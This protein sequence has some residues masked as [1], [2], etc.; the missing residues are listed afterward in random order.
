MPAR[1]ASVAG[2]K[3]TSAWAA[4]RT[5][6]HAGSPPESPR[7]PRLAAPAGISTRTC[8]WHR[9]VTTCRQRLSTTPDDGGAD[10]EEGE[11]SRWRSRAAAAASTA[12]AAC[13]SV[14]ASSAAASCS[15]ASLRASSTL[16]SSKPPTETTAMLPA[17]AE[18]D[19]RARAEASSSSMAAPRK[20]GAGAGAG[21]AE[22]VLVLS[23]CA[24]D[25]TPLASP[26]S[27]GKDSHAGACTPESSLDRV[28]AVAAA[29]T[30]PAA[31]VDVRATKIGRSVGLVM[32]SARGTDTAT[33]IVPRVP[34][35][36]A[37]AAGAAADANVAPRKAAEIVACSCERRPDAA[38]CGGS[39]VSLPLAASSG[40]S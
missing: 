40:S 31:D 26:C 38:R 35:S 2:E 1:C 37:S 19:A 13:S 27:A 3:S 33:V 14:S 34:A 5:C 36:P 23:A 18:A 28:N 32:R 4:A 6:S 24:P 20:E 8:S 21:E 17:E 25:G 30:G 11:T 15:S 16:I 12:P 22:L 7:L 29:G 10:E 9:S 39:K